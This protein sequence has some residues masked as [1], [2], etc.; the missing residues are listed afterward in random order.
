MHT[1]FL[2]T[3]FDPNIIFFINAKKHRSLNRCFLL[4]IYNAGD[5]NRTGTV[6]LQQDFKSCA[7]ASSATP[8][9]SICIASYVQRPS[10]TSYLKM[11]SYR[12]IHNGQRWIRTTEA[13]CSRFTVCPL[14]PLGNLP[15]YQIRKMRSDKKRL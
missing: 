4:R 5:R 7:S 14:W 1:R 11:S 13:N 3:L 6:F 8:A 2:N 10:L 15:I 12:T 9:F